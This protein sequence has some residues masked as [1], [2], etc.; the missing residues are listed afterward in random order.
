MTDS[1]QALR[2]EFGARLPILMYHNVGP[3]RERFDRYLTI[4]PRMFERQL[5]WL[6]QHRYTPIRTS[7]WIAHL[8]DGKALPDKP[9]LLTFDDAY[10]D[11]SEFGLPLLIKYGFT[12]TVFV[13]TD[14]IGG[15]NKWDLHLGLSEQPLM[16]E[17]Q[18]REWADKGIEFG[19]HTKTH[20]DLTLVTSEQVAEEMQG[21]RQRL[22]NL[23]GA[24][25]PSLAYP[26][27]YYNAE[28]AEIARRHFDLAL[29]CD[30]GL[31]YLGTDPLLLRRAEVVP[32]QTPGDM[33]SM[34]TLGCNLLFVGRHRLHRLARSIGRSLRKSLHFK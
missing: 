22:E 6:S 10:S 12:G 23:L 27:G 21:S 29:T 8:R 5:Q 24:P 14:Q 30:L 3:L 19:A 28:V 9:I 4:S 7:D 25:V 1:W 18:I 2:K 17:S 33:W 32:I 13:V 11:I 26:Y 16:S 34:V 20:A 31:N 15:T